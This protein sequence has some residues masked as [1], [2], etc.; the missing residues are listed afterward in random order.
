MPQFLSI[1][2]SMT[3]LSGLNFAQA[4]ELPGT[5]LGD[6]I[7]LPANKGAGEST[8]KLVIKFAK[9]YVIPASE[10]T[11]NRDLFMPEE[12]S[13]NLYFQ[14]GQW[15][16]SRQLNT[17]SG[18][19]CRLSVFHFEMHGG[20]DLNDKTDKS[21]KAYEERKK[22]GIFSNITITENMVVKDIYYS[23]GFSASAG[24]YEAGATASIPVGRWTI[25][26]EN[27]KQ[28]TWI[29]GSN[30]GDKVAGLL[31]NRSYSSTVAPK[32]SD[33]DVTIADLKSCFGADIKIVE[34]PADFVVP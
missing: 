1:L 31:I 32:E 29:L 9:P 18:T 21:F 15:V 34:V 23:G 10:I 16:P 5:E 20:W 14:N 25:K 24:R 28:S 4:Q 30:I 13:G 3:V 11:Q 17:K 2:F 27:G 26:N 22:N 6:S 8:S 7:K 33:L 19:F 12:E